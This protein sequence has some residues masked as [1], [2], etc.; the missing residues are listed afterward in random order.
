MQSFPVVGL[1]P[2]RKPSG[3]DGHFFFDRD[4]DA[5]RSILNGFRRRMEPRRPSSL[6]DEEWQAELR[7]WGLP[8]SEDEGK[9]DGELRAVRLL[10]TPPPPPPQPTSPRHYR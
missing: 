1:R 2:S 7:F 5:F 4:P 6:S 8:M 10:E 9:K 3:E